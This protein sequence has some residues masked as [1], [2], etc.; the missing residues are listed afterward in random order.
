MSDFSRGVPCVCG[1]AGEAEDE[2]PT[3][4]D[5]KRYR[6]VPRF[7]RVSIFLRHRNANTQYK[8]LMNDLEKLAWMSQSARSGRR[9]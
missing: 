2:A 1:V 5:G 3:T 6:R 9:K 4:N 8:I 7:E